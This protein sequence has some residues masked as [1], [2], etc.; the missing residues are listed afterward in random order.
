MYYTTP[1]LIT[2]GASTKLNEMDTFVISMHKNIQYAVVKGNNI[3]V[4]PIITLPRIIKGRHVNLTAINIDNTFTGII[5]CRHDSAHW[6]LELTADNIIIGVELCDFTYVK[7]EDALKNHFAVV[8]HCG[9]SH[10][11]FVPMITVRSAGWYCVNLFEEIF[12]WVRKVATTFPYYDHD[13]VI[14]LETIYGTRV[15]FTHHHGLLNIGF[16]DMLIK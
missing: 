7:S 12:K 5:S 16:E 13:T 6:F 8:K 4:K 2:D 3:A 14:V 10:K 11:Q 15:L 9:T 1:V